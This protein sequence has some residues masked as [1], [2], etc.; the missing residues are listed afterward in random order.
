M[1][2]NPSWEANRFAA[3]QD[4]PRIFM[5]PEGSLTRTTESKV[6]Y[7]PHYKTNTS[8]QKSNWYVNRNVKSL[9]G[10]LGLN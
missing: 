7:W 2:Q 10:L 6:R 5:E 3:S 9:K 1:E 4:I 8:T